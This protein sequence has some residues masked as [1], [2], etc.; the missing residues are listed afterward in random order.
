MS[1]TGTTTQTF[2]VADIRKVVDSFAAD[3][4]M[5]S[6]STGL[7]SPSEIR[8]TVADLKIFAEAG[9]LI[10]VTLILRDKAGTEIKGAKYKTS[11]AASG[12]VSQ[13]PG[14]SMWP[15]TPDGNLEIV[16]SLK[17]T[18]W[19]MTD[20]QRATFKRSKGLALPWPTTTTDTSLSGLTQSDGQRYASN[21]YG[22]ER[23]NYS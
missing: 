19:A 7:H 18:W 14:N 2:T 1:S 10:D 15:R 12:W 20:D 23:S 9:Y 6:E 11:D 22:L 16:A 5:M 8:S 17:S 21:G 3:Y 13:R 4:T